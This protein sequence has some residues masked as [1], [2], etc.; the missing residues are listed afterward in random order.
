MSIENLKK[1]EM[2]I[3]EDDLSE[4]RFTNLKISNPKYDSPFQKGK[5][6]EGE[7]SHGK[8]SGPTP[9]GNLKFLEKAGR[10]ASSGSQ[11]VNFKA[12]SVQYNDTLK[13]GE[14]A[15]KA[16]PNSKEREEGY[17]EFNKKVRDTLGSAERLGMS[18]ENIVKLQKDLY[19]P[20]IGE[21]SPALKGS[22]TEQM[23]VVA[24]RYGFGGLAQRL[25]ADKQM[26]SA[27]FKNTGIVTNLK[28]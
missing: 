24:N 15:M 23:R 5:A 28:T 16:P 7:K 1:Y 20:L 22:S 13:A 26:I 14:N 18:K 8:F 6:D 12:F 17:R 9:E 19:K 21:T 27:L 2:N 10:P 25:N 3:H 11:K 4:I